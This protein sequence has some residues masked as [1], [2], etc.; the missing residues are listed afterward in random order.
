MWVRLY[1]RLKSVLYSDA[2]LAR[3][4]VWRGKREQYGA[5]SLV[6]KLR[7]VDPATRV[8]SSLGTQTT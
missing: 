8:R 3:P 1:K 6:V 5:Y 2:L 7:S 4:A